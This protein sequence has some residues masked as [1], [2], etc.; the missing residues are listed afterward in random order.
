MYDTVENAADKLSMKAVY[1]HLISLLREYEL[2]RTVLL[3]LSPT[4]YEIQTLPTSSAAIE[5]QYQ[6]ILMEENNAL[7]V[8][9][10]GLSAAG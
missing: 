1:L 3:V 5:A 6:S 10:H 8:T 7:D 4:G 2:Y 9:Y